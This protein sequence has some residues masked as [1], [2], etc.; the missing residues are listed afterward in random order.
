MLGGVLTF[1]IWTAPRILC[2][3]DKGLINYNA[4]LRKPNHI[5]SSNQE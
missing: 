1:S 5:H 3:V 2:F 4:K